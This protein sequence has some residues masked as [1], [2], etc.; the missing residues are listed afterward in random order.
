MAVLPILCK[1]EDFKNQ[2]VKIHGIICD[3]LSSY[4]YLS[5]SVSI[6]FFK[7][8]MVPFNLIIGK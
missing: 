1:W 6:K 5:I 4:F 7:I 3:I 8:K 2:K